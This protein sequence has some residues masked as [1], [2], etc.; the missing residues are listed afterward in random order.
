M[1]GT[2][3]TH[4]NKRSALH[5]S[6]FQPQGY[7]LDWWWHQWVHP[8]LWEGWATAT[9]SCRPGSCFKRFQ[10]AASSLHLFPLVAPWRGVHEEVTI[11]RQPCLLFGMHIWAES[12]GHPSSFAYLP[13]RN[14]ATRKA[15]LTFSYL[16]PSPLPVGEVIRTCTNEYVADVCV[17]RFR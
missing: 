16:W 15:R 10:C 14:P 8:S 13:P 9:S 2:L 4:I 11:S 7:L 3:F 6:Q 1:W 17:D 5:D 12:R